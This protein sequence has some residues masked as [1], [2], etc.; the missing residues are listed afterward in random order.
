VI[1]VRRKAWIGIAVA[2]IAALPVALAAGL[3]LRGSGSGAGNGGAE[4]PPRVLGE[5]VEQEFAN[6][7]QARGTVNGVVKDAIT[8]RAVSD[9]VIRIISRK[10]TPLVST[11]SAPGGNYSISGPEGSFTLQVNH[12]DYISQERTILLMRGM[13]TEI[14]FSLQRK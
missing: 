1:F 2:L 12:P 4:P 8:G 10:G 6:I 11:S 13:A 9:A 14:N 3:S 7:P 5:L